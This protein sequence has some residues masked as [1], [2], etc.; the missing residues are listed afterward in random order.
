MRDVWAA[1]QSCI[2]TRKLRPL[3]PHGFGSCCSDVGQPQ[4]PLP[5]HGAGEGSG[6][7]G[8]RARLGQGEGVS[9]EKVIPAAHGSDPTF[10][11]NLSCQG[12]DSRAAAPDKT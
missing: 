8:I 7:G 4:S 5:A 10:Q 9:C 6:R 11:L 12:S 1:S 3:G 2:S